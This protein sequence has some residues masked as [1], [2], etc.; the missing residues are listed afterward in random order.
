LIGHMRRLARGGKMGFR[1]AGA[2]RVRC[3]TGVPQIA[4]DFAASRKSSGSGQQGKS[5]K[6]PVRTDQEMVDGAI[7]RGR[8]TYSAIASAKIAFPCVC[9][10]QSVKRKT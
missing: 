10:Y 2:V 1:K 8:L 4:D 5:Q 9:K 6:Q 3:T 7:K